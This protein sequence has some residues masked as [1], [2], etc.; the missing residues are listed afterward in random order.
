MPPVVRFTL[1]SGKVRPRRTSASGTQRIRRDPDAG[2]DTPRTRRPRGV[3]PAACIGSP[4]RHAGVHPR[5]RSRAR[6]HRGGDQA[7]PPQSL[8]QVRA[9]RRHREP[10]DRAGPRGGPAWLRGRPA[11]ARAQGRQRAG[12]RSVGRRPTGLVRGG[13]SP[14]G[15]GSDSAARCGRPRAPRRLRPTWAGQ[16]DMST[17]VREQ[18]YAAYLA[19]ADRR[20]AAR[21]ALGLGWNA[22]VTLRFPVCRRMARRSGPAPRGR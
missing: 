1:P 15:G 5:D 21:V 11:R 9:P 14:V 8:R 6:G 7:A 4:R 19:R 2:A 12:D 18:A 20:S 13:R 3:V 17:A 10:A 16:F 22:A